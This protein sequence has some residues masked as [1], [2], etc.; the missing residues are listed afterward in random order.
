MDLFSKEVQDEMEKQKLYFVT[1]EFLRALECPNS[2]CCGGKIES[3]GPEP[4]SEACPWCEG[5]EM[6]LAR[7]RFNGA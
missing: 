2:N 6:V 5:R 1:E 4:M 7:V 3:T